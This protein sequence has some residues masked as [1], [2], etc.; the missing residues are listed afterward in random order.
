MVKI[1][2]MVEQVKRNMAQNSFELVFSEMNIYLPQ[3]HHNHKA[4]S[5]HHR[6]KQHHGHLKAQG[7]KKEIRDLPELRKRQPAP[8]QLWPNR[9]HH[10]VGKQTIGHGRP[11]P[12]GEQRCCTA[13]LSMHTTSFDLV[14]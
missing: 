12:S 13:T 11:D 14:K 2:F 9:C 5:D 7:E 1:S 8:P 6:H 3:D 10:A 4:G